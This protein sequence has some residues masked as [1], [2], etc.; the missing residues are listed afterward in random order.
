MP[1]FYPRRKRRYYPRYRRWRFGRPIRRHRWRRRR[2]RHFNLK[3]LKN[4]FLKQWQPPCIKKC[5]IKGLNCIVYTNHQR[6]SWDSTL[7]DNSTVPE[8]EPGGGGFA[9]TKFDLNCLWTLHQKCQ[10]WWTV[11]NEN[12]PL[13]RYMGLRV[14]LYRCENIDYVIAYQNSGPFVSN[15]LTYASCQPA[16]LMMR[17]NKIIVSS[18]K[19]NPRKK[20][21]KTI[22][23]K[24]PSLIQN[25]W[26]F[27]S[28]FCNQTLVI[29]HCAPVSLDHFYINPYSES[30]NISIKHLNTKLIQNQN[31][32]DKKYDTQHWPF[33]GTGTQKYYLYRYTGP[34][35]INQTNDFLVKDICPITYIKSPREGASYEEAIVSQK[36]LKAEEYKQNL[37]KKYAGSIFQTQNFV[38]HDPMFYTTQSPENMWNKFSESN[39]NTLKVSETQEW[40]SGFVHVTENFISYTRYNPN[41]DTGESTKM[42]LT[43]NNKDLQAWEPP[44]NPNLILSGFPLWLNI[45]GFIDFQKQLKIL[46]GID[47][48][49][50]LCF[51]STA[52]RPIWN[53]TF[54]VIDQN[55]LDNKNPYGEFL[56]DPEYST[57]W[58]KV[59]NQ[60]QSINDIT[61]T[62]PGI[63]KMQNIKSENIKIEYDFYF[64]WGGD[65]AKMVT[66]D[67]PSDQPAYPVPRNE[68]EKPSLQGPTQGYETVVYSFDQR[69]WQFTKAALERMQKDWETERN[70][71]SITE[72]SRT[73]PIVE[74]LQKVYQKAQ[75]EEE[76]QETLLQQLQYNKQQQL[77]LKQ[78]ILTMISQLEKLE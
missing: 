78:R 36:N 52:T 6:L 57:F 64:K 20:P 66:I 5:H 21:Y 34:L 3:K 75:T 13:C 76:R 68:H 38:Q 70:V 35:H 50:I 8:H 65:P 49:C 4:I 42:W 14:R 69:N 37:L 58:P 43:T 9:V 25:K 31:F 15:K 1:W 18:K 67:N 11:G 56:K 55:F 54:V 39:K 28:E 32:A 59:A 29:F 48:N 53:H 71:F 62:G 7:Y 26:Y 40:H 27:Q 46:T 23:I 2:V 74:T 61:C 10:N 24:P 17:K 45:F 30:N 72:P 44:D 22:H 60:V 47:T 77:Q 73:V 41:I 51:Q 33:K 12:L 19:T 16:M 63:V